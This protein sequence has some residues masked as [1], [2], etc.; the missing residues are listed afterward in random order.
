ML[1]EEIATGVAVSLTSDIMPE[2]DGKN[3]FITKYA[4]IAKR[5]H[6]FQDSILKA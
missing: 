6:F 1:G 2:T 5:A 3:G 4:A